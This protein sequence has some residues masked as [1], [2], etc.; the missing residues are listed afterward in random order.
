M[1]IVV[2]KKREDE[3]L[4]FTDGIVVDPNAIPEGYT[5]V[6][7]QGAYN[8]DGKRLT[9]VEL[10]EIRNAEPPKSEVDLLAEQLINEKFKNM[11]LQKDIDM[12]GSE[13]AKTKF[14][15]MKIQKVGV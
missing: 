8:E 10:E 12:L 11:Q 13:M 2:Y 1:K 15:L 6:K 9:Q 14:D 3:T 7:E 5:E 4:D